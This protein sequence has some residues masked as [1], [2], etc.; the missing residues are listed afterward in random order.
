MQNTRL[1]HACLQGAFSNTPLH[2]TLHTYTRT[3]F[4]TEEFTIPSPLPSYVQTVLRIL[5]LTEATAEPTPSSHGTLPAS[6]GMTKHTEE[7][8]RGSV[9]RGKTDIE[10]R[11]LSSRELLVPVPFDNHDVTSHFEHIQCGACSICTRF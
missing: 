6:H 8:E 10:R 4:Y 7:M 1:H 2:P 11:V 5:K 3:L 9:V